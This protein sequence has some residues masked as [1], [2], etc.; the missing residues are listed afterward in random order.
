MFDTN[1]WFWSRWNGP[2][3]N[4]SVVWKHFADRSDIRIN[5]ER[6]RN[7]TDSWEEEKQKPNIYGLMQSVKKYHM[8]LVCSLR[9]GGSD[10]SFGFDSFK[11][12]RFEWKLPGSSFNA[13]SCVK[14]TVR[15]SA[16]HDHVPLTPPSPRGWKGFGVTLV[17]E[18]VILGWPSLPSA[19]S[20]QVDPELLLTD[21]L[22]CFT[23]S[24]SFHKNIQDHSAQAGVAMA[25]SDKRVFFPLVFVSILRIWWRKRWFHNQSPARWYLVLW[26]IGDTD[27]VIIAILFAAQYIQKYNF[28]GWKNTCCLCHK[29]IIWWPHLKYAFNVLK[30]S[31]QST[32]AE[33]NIQTYKL[34]PL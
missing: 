29:A 18:A 26:L 33:K 7:Q 4:S 21:R 2:C 1:G 23:A 9:E 3:L 10:R 27:M 5:G 13:W 22:C 15:W 31:K 17:L 11:L 12:H 24:A 25:T 34:D 30:M 20:V 16:G 14:H 32:L 19:T 28:L 6:R 8:S